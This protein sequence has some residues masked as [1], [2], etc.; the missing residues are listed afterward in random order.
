MVRPSRENVPYRT[1]KKLHGVDHCI[2][3]FTAC[4]VPFDAPPGKLRPRQKE[5]KRIPTNYMRGTR[6]RMACTN[7]SRYAGNE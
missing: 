5:G 1:F 3:R 7:S 2:R 6:K 4:D